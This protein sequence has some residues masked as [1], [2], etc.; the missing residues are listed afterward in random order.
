MSHHFTG[1]SYDI[2]WRV[3]SNILRI[4]I[5]PLCTQSAVVITNQRS[6][7]IVIKYTIVHVI[8]T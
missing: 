7:V 1:V 3:V 6:N 8:F 4:I 5:A 2:T